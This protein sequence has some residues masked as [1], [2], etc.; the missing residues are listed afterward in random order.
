MQAFF[1]PSVRQLHSFARRHVP[2]IISWFPSFRFWA[3]E[4]NPVMVAGMFRRFL[5]QLD[6]GCE[7]GHGSEAA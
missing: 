4:I 6:G 1:E 5:P 2:E 7:T 3:L